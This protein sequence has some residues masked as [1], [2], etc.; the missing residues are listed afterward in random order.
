MGGNERAVGH[1]KKLGSLQLTRVLRLS[2][3]AVVG[4]R[5]SV[6]DCDVEH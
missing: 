1:V 4:F 3:Y 5:A 2:I 6:S